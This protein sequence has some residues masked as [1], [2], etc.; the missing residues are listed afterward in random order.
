M[1]NGPLVKL[2]GNKIL[3]KIETEILR[4]SSIHC[5]L[6]KIYLNYCISWCHSSVNAYGRHRS[7]NLMEASLRKA[8]WSFHYA[9]MQDA[10]E[11]DF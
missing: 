1:P 2:C 3:D 8:Y 5:R 4:N 11:R 6:L 10:E 9:A 7:K